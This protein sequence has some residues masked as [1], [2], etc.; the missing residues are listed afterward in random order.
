MIKIYERRPW[1]PAKILLVVG[2]GGAGKSSLGLE[3]APLL[4]RHL[5]DLD[6]EFRNRR[7]DISAFLA[8]E[9]YERYKIENAILAA[10]I[11]AEAAA[12][13]VLIAPSG[14]LT[15]DNP[16]AVLKANHSLSRACYSVCLLPS[17]DLERSVRVIVARQMERPFA[18]DRAS[19]E[20]TIRA[21]YSVYAKLGDLLVFSNASPR[22]TAAAVARHCA[23]RA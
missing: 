7:G 22:E 14:F 5:V 17:S 12:P 8:S 15:P 2:P 20:A 21:R 4:N 18:R 1:Y 11:V 3:L 23:K 6:E 16:E 19:E 10:H 9:G 13:T